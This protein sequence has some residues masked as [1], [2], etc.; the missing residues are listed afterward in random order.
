MN[1]YMAWSEH[2]YS[3]DP[4]GTDSGTASCIY[5]GDCH[6][7]SSNP[8]SPGILIPCLVAIS[9]SESREFAQKL[10]FLAI[11]KTWHVYTACVLIVHVDIINMKVRMLNMITI[12]WWVGGLLQR[13]TVA[14]SSH[15]RKL[16]RVTIGGEPW[17]VIENKIMQNDT[18]QALDTWSRGESVSTRGIPVWKYKLRYWPWVG[19]R[20]TLQ[21]TVSGRECRTRLAWLWSLETYPVWRV[22]VSN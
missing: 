10:L 9:L 14:T 8:L 2:M 16:K 12:P 22:L 17:R 5:R 3:S 20:G 11:G 4:T 1:F 7:I 19:S 6:G 18:D 13:N 15:W 21:T